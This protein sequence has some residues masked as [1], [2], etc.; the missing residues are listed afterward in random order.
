MGSAVAVSLEASSSGS[1]TQT[2]VGHRYSS[3]ASILE[4]VN[5]QGELKS[6]PFSSQSS[7]MCNLETANR[8]KKQQKRAG[9][10]PNLYLLAVSIDHLSFLKLIFFHLYIYICHMYTDVLN[11]R[12]MELEPV[13]NHLSRV[14]G[15]ELWSYGRTFS[16]LNPWAISLLHHSTF[17]WLRSSVDLFLVI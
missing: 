11:P 6:R 2:Q 17:P 13:V 1:Y 15:T 3:L 16:A 4:C 8:H 7:Q 5:K 12:E 10:H 14:L 9:T